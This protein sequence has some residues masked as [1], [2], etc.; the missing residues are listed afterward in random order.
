[1]FAR[2]RARP[3]ALVERA[4]ASCP[5]VPVKNGRDSPSLPSHGNVPVA[6]R[7]RYR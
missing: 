1:V 2:D 5:L 7:G 3:L 6:A 4:D